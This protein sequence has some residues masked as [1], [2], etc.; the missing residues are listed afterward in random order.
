MITLKDNGPVRFLSEGET[1]FDELSATCNCVGQDFCQIVH[2]GDST[3]FQLGISEVSGVNLVS[4]GTFASDTVWTKGSGWTISLNRA[5]HS[6]GGG[7]LSQSVSGLTG[8]TYYKITFNVSGYSNSQ[9]TTVTFA[10]DTVKTFN[11]N[12]SY[13]VYW[14]TDATLSAT[15][16]GFTPHTSTSLVIDDVVIYEMSTVTYGIKDINDQVVKT[17]SDGTGVTYYQ[18][19]ASV[20]VDWSDIEEGCYRLFIIDNSTNHFEDADTGNF[21]TSE[22]GW[23]V[24][25]GN[26]VLLTRTDAEVSDLLGSYKGEILITGAELVTNGDFSS[27]T[28]WS[29]NPNGFSIGSG[30]LTHAGAASGSVNRAI[31][32]TVGKK[33]RITFTVNSYTAI[34]GGSS[35]FIGTNIASHRV[36]ISGAGDYVGEVTLSAVGA[37]QV[38][39]VSDDDLE[40]DNISVKEIPAS[41]SG[42]SSKPTEELIF[43]GDTAI[44]VQENSDY[45]ITAWV[46]LPNTL[47]QLTYTNQDFIYL[48]PTNYALSQCKNVRGIVCDLGTASSPAIRICNLVYENGNFVS[49]DVKYSSASAFSTSWYQITTVFNSGSNTSINLGLYFNGNLNNFAGGGVLAPGVYFYIDSLSL[50]GPVETES[51]CFKLGEFECTKLLRWS[52]NENAY[53]FTYDGTTFEHELRVK[54]KLWMPKYPKDKKEVFVDSAGNRRILT[55]RTK[56]EETFTVDHLPEYLHDALSIGVEHDNF[57]I[58]DVKYINEDNDYDP[59]WRKSSL[60]APVEIIVVKDSQDLSNSYC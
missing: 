27:S 2:S 12:G 42:F 52:N 58:D 1:A 46:N 10:G 51:E 41:G 26:K 14:F 25:E 28:G 22:S 54:S 20:E 18:N 35:V 48:R 50:R 56:K 38:F 6:S 60:T 23:N 47:V 36:D 21:E 55:S 49:R 7:T 30:V 4:N 29:I 31:S 59:S 32:L 13:T 44:D 39:V 15:T 37:G 53:G 3:P 43:S 9:T 5:S 33:Y 57:Y 34:G 24:T 8:S 45:I 19:T 17:V 11:A 40:L 16:I